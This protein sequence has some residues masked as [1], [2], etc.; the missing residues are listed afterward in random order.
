MPG[1]GKQTSAGRVVCVCVCGQKGL[2]GWVQSLCVSKQWAIV[3]EC[4]QESHS[5]FSC[6]QVICTAEMYVSKWAG[7]YVGNKY[8]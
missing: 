3:Q 2:G 7:A 5:V 4:V 8:A 6:I 1:S